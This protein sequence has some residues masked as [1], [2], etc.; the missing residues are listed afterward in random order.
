MPGR[1]SGLFYT[2]FFSKDVQLFKHSV[3]CASIVLSQFPYQTHLSA[4]NYS[5]QERVLHHSCE[6]LSVAPGEPGI[7]RKESTGQSECRGWLL[8]KHDGPRASFYHQ[9]NHVPNSSKIQLC[10]VDMISEFP[11]DIPVNTK[12][13][14]LVKTTEVQ[15]FYVFL[16]GVLDLKHFSH[17]TSELRSRLY[18]HKGISLNSSLMFMCTCT[19]ALSTK[20]N[21]SDSFSVHWTTPFHFQKWSQF[22]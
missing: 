13:W 2:F 9:F 3:F 12:I 7:A 5:L 21:I 17:S 4:L 15:L 10:S 16:Y 11:M 22:L 20:G 14:H 19:T 6:M 18:N 1:N 8:D